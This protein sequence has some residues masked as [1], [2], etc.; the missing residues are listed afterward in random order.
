MNECR[1]TQKWHSLSVPF[2][3]NRVYGLEYT[4]CFT[5]EKWSHPIALILSYEKE[6]SLQLLMPITGSNHWFRVSYFKVSYYDLG[7]LKISLIIYYFQSL[8]IVAKDRLMGLPEIWRLVSKPSPATDPLCNP[9]KIPSTLQACTLWSR[10]W[11]GGQ[12]D[13]QDFFP[14]PHCKIPCFCLHLKEANF[15]NKGILISFWDQSCSIGRMG[16]IQGCLM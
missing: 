2:D 5:W 7:V 15:P 11:G 10:K 6:K 9:E 4:V 16:R 12:D 1:I 14:L 13:L 8:F 3:V